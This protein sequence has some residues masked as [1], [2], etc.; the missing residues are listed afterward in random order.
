MR[1]VITDMKSPL[2]YGITD[3][4]LPAYFSQGPVLNVGGGRGGAGAGG[5]RGANMYAQ[6]TQPMALENQVPISSIAIGG[7]APE[8]EAAGRRRSR[9]TWRP[10]WA[11]RWRGRRRRRAG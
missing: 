8:A 6:N 5:G 3:R 11:W 1:G 2:A 9:R 4:E 7:A 10:R